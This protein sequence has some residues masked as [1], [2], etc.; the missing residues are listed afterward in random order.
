[1]TDPEGHGFKPRR[2]RRSIPVARPKHV[3][4]AWG[5]SNE[6][7]LRAMNLVT[8]FQWN[9]APSSHA[10]VDMQA[11]VHAR[12]LVPSVMIVSLRELACLRKALAR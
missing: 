10:I 7:E 6:H 8:N 3:S 5:V 9:D 12:R 1:M 11:T 2:A 4:Y